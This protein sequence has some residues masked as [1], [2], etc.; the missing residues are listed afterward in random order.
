MPSAN[1]A[2]MLGQNHITNPLGER[3]E[4]STKLKSTKHRENPPR[5][6][7]EQYFNVLF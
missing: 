1:C 5:E 3:M 7:R 2:K 4:N 6:F